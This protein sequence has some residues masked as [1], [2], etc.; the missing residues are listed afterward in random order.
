MFDGEYLIEDKFFCMK[1]YNFGYD[2][3]YIKYLISYD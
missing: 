2:N 3:Y 1:D